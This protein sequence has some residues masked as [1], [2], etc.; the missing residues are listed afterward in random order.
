[1]KGAV[2][3]GPRGVRFETAPVPKI[4]QPTDAVLRVNAACACG[5]DLWP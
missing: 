4:E 5:S 1:M 3:H 2:I